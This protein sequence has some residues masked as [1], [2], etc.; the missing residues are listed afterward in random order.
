MRGDNPMGKQHH[1]LG[2]HADHQQRPIRGI[3]LQ[4]NGHR[5]LYRQRALAAET[6]HWLQLQG[7]PLDWLD[8]QPCADGWRYRLTAE[9]WHTF[10]PGW[11]TLDLVAHQNGEL[12]LGTEI[13]LALLSSPVD[14]TFPNLE[15]LH[16]HLE[17]RL[18]TCRAAEETTLAFATQSADRPASHWRYS[19]ATGFILQPGAALIE[20]LRLATQPSVSGSLY[21]F[22]CYRATE[23]VLLLG[24]AQT[25]QK[26]NPDLLYRLEDQW[27][28]EA[29]ASGRFHDTFLDEI[30]SM[31]DPLPGLHYVPGDR[32]WF[33]NPDERSADVVGFEGSWVVYMGRG[34]FTDFWRPQSS[35]SLRDKCLEIHFWREAVVEKP[36]A[37]ST[38]D[39]TRVWERMRALQDGLD[40]DAGWAHE[41][42]AAIL[43]RMMRY[44]DT[45]GVYA[46][47]GCIDTTR[48][49]LRW[50]CPGF[51]RIDLPSEQP[52]SA[53]NERGLM[54]G[55][56]RLPI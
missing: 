12:P 56:S 15:E 50:M 29:I 9:A 3:V 8:V 5:P 52:L 41:Q 39:E 1:Q 13:L 33:R 28:R 19:E 24:L 6:S 37:E 35:Y 10:T 40:A 21:D 49:H 54:T 26:F 48:E 4:Q 36:G 27:R 38:I 51:E 22:S 14:R 31:D 16:A 30:G 43:R 32:V 44:R 18:Y 17:S 23:Y 20:A 45:R 47:G 11:D 55:A 34:R 42:E 25:L 53:D 46:E 7:I 2:G